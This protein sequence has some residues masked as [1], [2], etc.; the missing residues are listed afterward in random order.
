[1]WNISSVL[2]RS[3][4]QYLLLL[5]WLFGSSCVQAEWPGD[6][7]LLHG[8]VALW[9]PAL[10]GQAAGPPLCQRLQNQVG[11]TH[12]SSLT[13]FCQW[14]HQVY[15]CVLIMQSSLLLVSPHR[16]QENISEFM[17]KCFS[18]QDKPGEKIHACAHTHTLCLLVFLSEMV[19]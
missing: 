16:S 13:E 10:G 14:S 1:M 7:E 17:T 3:S 11:E 19:N 6:H 4:W 18:S 2:K 8:S 9:T 12:L 15:V 5:M